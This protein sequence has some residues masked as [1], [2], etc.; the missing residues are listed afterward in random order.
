MSTWTKSPR[1]HWQWNS[2]WT[3]DIL[4]SFPRPWGHDLQRSTELGL[5]SNRPL[6]FEVRFLPPKFF[7]RCESWRFW[8]GNAAILFVLSLREKNYFVIAAGFVERLL[9]SLAGIGI[10]AVDDGQPGGK[11]DIQW[12]SEYYWYSNAESVSNLWMVCWPNRSKFQSP[13]FR[14]FLVF[15]FKLGSE[16]LPKVR[17]SDPQSCNRTVLMTQLRNL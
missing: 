16:N 6:F 8:R 7:E 3:F 11:N 5:S 1:P 4:A 15:L 17:Y 2:S 12:R 9:V 14:H 13:R 10:W